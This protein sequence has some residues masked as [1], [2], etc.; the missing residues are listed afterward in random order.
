MDA[1]ADVDFAV[2]MSRHGG[3][4]FINLEGLYTRYDD[5]SS[6]IERVAA[7]ASGQEAAHVL[8]EAYE[9][10]VRDEL[11]TALITRIKAQ[12]AIAAVATAPAS[13]RPHAALAS[14]TGAGLFLVS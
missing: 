6:I 7:A 2:R 10:R 5:A 4:A 3:V 11:I 12:G 9:Q 13:D 14:Q 1:V 8:A